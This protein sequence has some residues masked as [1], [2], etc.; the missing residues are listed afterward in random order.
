MDGLSKETENKSNAQI[1]K[2]S[3]LAYF[4][5]AVNVVA[6]II[7]T[8]WMVRQI[9]QSNYGMYTLAVS[10]ISILMF[11]F[12]IGT[13]IT[14]FA[15]LYRSSGDETGLKHFLGLIYK[16]YFAIDIVA[17]VGSCILYCFLDV[18]YTSFT[19]LELESFKIVYMLVAGYNLLALP[20]SPLDGLLSAYEEFVVIKACQLL[21]RVLTIVLV[22]IALSMGQGL[23]AL[24]IANIISG[25]V[26]IAIRWLFVHYK[27]KLKAQWN[28]LDWNMIRSVLSFSCLAMIGSLCS[29]LST[30]LMPSIV[31]ATTGTAET[32]I[33]GAATTLNGYAYLL[34]NAISGMFLPKVTRILMKENFTGKLDQLSIKVGRLLM[35]L[36]A[37]ILVG[38]F[39]VG[40]NFFVLWMGEPYRKAYLCTCFLIFA[41]LAF[42]PF[43][44]YNTAMTA[45]GYLKPEAFNRAVTSAIIV[46][47]GVGVSRFF[48]AAGAAM[49]ICV[50]YLIRGGISLFLYRK[51]LKVDIKRFLKEVYGKT[52]I[53]IGL[54]GVCIICMKQFQT[55]GWGALILQSTVILAS[56]ILVTF[57]FV[58]EEQEKK[59][60]LAILQRAIKKR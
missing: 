43:Q 16:I 32:A 44:I 4:A 46:T 19:P 34:T 59:D 51:Y 28:G 49:A 2:G 54:A 1:L 33:Y 36:S 5:L 6:G 52:P 11:D 40:E 18:I 24:V 3:G 35:I 14:R 30:N 21:A 45:K 39:S 60:F 25:I 38:F 20:F 10:L 29:S 8:P 48:G 7:Y 12:G 50:G 37:V 13:A 58:L 27:L 47:V 42:N 15:A 56:F 9:G 23:Y 26:S 57:L 17:L 53:Y 55:G 31:A 41:E 22:V